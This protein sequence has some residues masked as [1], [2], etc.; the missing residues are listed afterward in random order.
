V[1]RR[2]ARPISRR[3]TVTTVAHPHKKIGLV[4]SVSAYSA[5]LFILRSPQMVQYI[6][7]AYAK[8]EQPVE[9][10]PRTQIAGFAFL[11][12]LSIALWWHA[13]VSTLGLALS[14]EA[15]THM[16]LIVPLSLALIY[17]EGRA[18]PRNCKPGGTAG[19]FLLAGALLI[20]GFAGWGAPSLG[21]DLRLSVRMFAMVIWWIASVVFC[22]GVGT[23]RRFLFPLCF[24]FWAVPVPAVVLNWIILVLQKESASTT[25]VLFQI[26]GV[27]VAQD[28]TVLKIP[29]L[30]LYVAPECS[31]IRSSLVLIMTTMVLAHLFLR[32]WW[33]KA[34]IIAVAVPLA[35]AKNG[36]RIF[37][38]AELGTR[39][40]R[41]FFDG[42][43]HQHGGIVFLGIAVVVVV[44]LIWFL[45]RWEV[46]RP[47]ELRAR[48]S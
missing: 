1:H 23:F 28:G 18:S 22:F 11:C 26:A 2:D 34:L 9:M 42:N 44:A 14:E 46:R 19:A 21:V 30:T 20:A 4:V 6:Q 43:L 38:I 16:V 45:H 41:G 29:G 5:G 12:G 47:R 25:R 31:S 13:L 15:Y 7:P 48:L 3:K 37:V 36:L 24:L 32:S 40:D 39:V 17:L 27:P 10:T 33:R 35:V 8:P